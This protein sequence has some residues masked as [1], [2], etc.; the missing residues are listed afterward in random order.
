MGKIF[1]RWET[2]MFRWERYFDAGKRE[3]F[4]GKNIF[5]LGNANVPLGK[6]FLRWETQMLR[7]EKYF[8]AEKRKCSNE[9]N[10]FSLRNFDTTIL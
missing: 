5:T 2:Q 7:W 6:I 3:C 4:A 1:S 9:K 10:I 8:L